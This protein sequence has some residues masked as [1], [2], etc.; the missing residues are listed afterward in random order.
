MK[1]LKQQLL[2][3]EMLEFSNGEDWAI[4]W[5]NKRTQNFV[6]EFNAKVIKATKTL[7]PIINKIEEHN[8]DLV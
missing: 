3:G 4:T 5:F 2:N 7:K 8:L 6:L 1:D